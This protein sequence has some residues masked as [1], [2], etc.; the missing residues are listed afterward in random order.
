MFNKIIWS[1][2]CILF[3]KNFWR[4]GNC[5]VCNVDGN[6]H[7]CNVD[8]NCHVCNVWK[9]QNIAVQLPISACLSLRT[10]AI[11]AYGVVWWLQ[12]KL[13]K[14]F[15]WYFEVGRNHVTFA[16]GTEMSRL[17][18]GRKVT[19]AMIRRCKRCVTFAIVLTV[20]WWN[21]MALILL[22]MSI[23]KTRSNTNDSRKR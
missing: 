7:V 8:G 19:F 14:T 10:F 18:W 11:M 4:D 12:M 1:L 22:N 2:Q 23:L 20:N 6:C 17:Q 16:M 5:H 13:R 3:N 15:K 21:D 9:L